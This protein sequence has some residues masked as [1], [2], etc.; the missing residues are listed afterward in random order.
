MKD[1]YEEYKCRACGLEDESQEH[2]TNCEILLKM[3]NEGEIREYKKLNGSNISE[4]KQICKQFRQ[5]MKML[6][7]Y[8]KN[9]KIR[10][11]PL[12]PSDQMFSVSAVL[13]P[14]YG[15]ISELE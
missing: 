12:G 3:N 6:Q 7:E 5:N 9:Q 4:L 1:L 14:V 2:V 8:E 13:G 15:P 10:N 11:S